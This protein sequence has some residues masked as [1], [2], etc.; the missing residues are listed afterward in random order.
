MFALGQYAGNKDAVNNYV[1]MHK[2]FLFGSG[3]TRL[4]CHSS[5][6]LA[7]SWQLQAGVS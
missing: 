3:A 6:A 4:V 5:V 1:V 7:L 2:D